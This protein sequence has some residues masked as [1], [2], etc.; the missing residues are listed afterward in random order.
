MSVT[1]FVPSGQRVAVTVPVAAVVRR[2][3][4]TGVEVVTGDMRLLRW[5]RLG[6]TIGDRVEV[7]SGL[8]AGEQIAL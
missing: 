7:L 8:E 4:L 5:V 1:A 2:G 3:Q 6:R